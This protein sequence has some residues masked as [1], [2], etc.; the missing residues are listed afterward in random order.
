[1]ILFLDRPAVSQ[2][3]DERVISVLTSRY[4][5]SALPIMALYKA[6]IVD[7]KMV[8]L[9]QRSTPSHA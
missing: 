4:D 5:L 6:K 3:T 1:M 2:L 9:G 7:E 8:A